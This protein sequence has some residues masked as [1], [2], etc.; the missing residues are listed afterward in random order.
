[1]LVSILRFFNVSGGIMM[2]LLDFAFVFSWIF[3]ITYFILYGFQI[4]HIFK[5]KSVEGLSLLMFIFIFSGNLMLAFQAFIFDFPISYKILIPMLVFELLIL[6]IQFFSFKVKIRGLIIK[7]LLV[8]SFVCLG[9]C[10]F[11]FYSPIIVGV[12]AGWL[13]IFFGTVAQLPQIYKIYNSKSSVGLSSVFMHLLGLT[14]ILECFTSLV[15][16]VPI[17]LKINGVRV[18]LV[19]LVFYFLFLKYREKN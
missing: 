9:S 5:K 14:S 11:I 4:F 3:N 16:N 2:N 8:S 12:I 17:F 19:F 13:T 18:I 6:L 7:F 1:M 10:Y 15:L